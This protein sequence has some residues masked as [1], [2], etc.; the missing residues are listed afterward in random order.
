MTGVKGKNHFTDSDWSEPQLSP[1]YEK[2]KHMAE[3]KAWEIYQQNQDK[4]QLSI[5]CPGWIQGPSFH[6]NAFTSGDL[7]IRV[8]NNDLPAVPEVS[9]GMVDVRDVALA[10]IR[11]IQKLS[12]T[13]AK[14]YILVENSYWLEDI[15]SIV[16]DEFAKYGYKMPCMSAGKVLL[17]MT[18]WFDSQIKLLLPYVGRFTTFDNRRS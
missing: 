16:K 18:S 3:K 15:V 2:S 13:N 5:I 6:K 11:C 10:H 12:E 14:R 1:P 17:T 4:I 8:F 9:F 7:L